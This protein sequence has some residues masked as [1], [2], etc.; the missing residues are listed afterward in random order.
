MPGKRERTRELILNISYALF[1]KKG[2][3]QVTMK[4]ICDAANLSRGGL[5]SHFS[6]TGEIFE[7]ILQK[8]NEKE[9]MNFYDEM[10]KSIPAVEIM[11]RALTLMKNEMNHPEDSLSL[12][13]YEY[14]DS[15]NSN[16][17]QHFNEVGEKKWKALI[18]YGIARDEF[19]DV[20]VDE[21]VNV[22]LYAYQGVRMWSRIVPM[23]SDVF[24]SIINHIKKQLIKEEIQDG[25]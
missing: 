17:M 14:S 9:E 7:A 16:L 12:A 3:H 5:Y 2:F 15:V 10:E 22:I 6:G 11:N 20:D 23:T 4:D 25:I 13:M 19:F 8:L 24:N 18:R 21:F 1:A